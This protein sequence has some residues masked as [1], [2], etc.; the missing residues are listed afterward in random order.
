LNLSDR[1]R[2]KYANG[3]FSIENLIGRIV[4]DR[5]KAQFWEF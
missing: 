1:K 4:E 3:K 5:W 2:G